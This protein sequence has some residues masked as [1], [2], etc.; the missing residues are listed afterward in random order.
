MSGGGGNQTSTTKVTY[1]PQEQ[2]ARDKI[3]QAAEGSFDVSRAWTPYAGALPT[4]A[5]ASTRASWDMANNASAK[6]VNAN[7]QTQ[8]TNTDIMRNAT[9]VGANPH[10]QGAMDAA[11]RPMVEQFMAPGG[12]LSAIRQGSVQN[13][14][15]GGSRQGIAEGMALQGLQRNVL[16]TRSGMASDAY[17]KGLEAQEGAIK[18]QAMLNMMH[19]MPSQIQ[20]QV[21]AQYEGYQQNRENYM[22]AAR[23]W[24]QNYHWKPLEN[25]AN[26]VYGG[27]NGTTQSTQSVPKTDNTGQIIGSLGTAA[28]MAMM[29]SS[30]VRL[31]S[32]IQR[33]G[34]HAKGFGIYLY[35]IFDKWQVGVLAQEVR[36]ILP[37]AVHVDRNGYYVVDYGSLG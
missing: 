6:I 16:D 5:S 35:K 1:S 8:N 31:K 23:D 22:A 34:T 19:Q 13:N 28:M 14:T 32:H 27:S 12:A 10:L 3:A 15:V 7:N 11:T 2:Q 18:N 24:D 4:P 37:G 20:G 36:K 29:M 9:N 17:Y 25:F 26:I 21:G 33:I 30:D